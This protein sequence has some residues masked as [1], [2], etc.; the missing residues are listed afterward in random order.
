L[1]YLMC[2]FVKMLCNLFENKFALLIDK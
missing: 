2:Y 1:T